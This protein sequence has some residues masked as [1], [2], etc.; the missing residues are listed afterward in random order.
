[1]LEGRD[2]AQKRLVQEQ[3]GRKTQAILATS[4]S[5]QE[6]LTRD[7]FKLNGTLKVKREDNA[8]LLK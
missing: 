6:G 5:L 3:R 1:M 8:A 4:F 7:K 2:D